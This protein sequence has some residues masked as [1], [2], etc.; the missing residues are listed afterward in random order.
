VKKHI[1][2]ILTTLISLNGYCQ[3]E[4]INFDTDSSQ[5]ELV[6]NSVY[7]IWK[8]SYKNKD[9]VFYSVRYVK[10]TTQI[11]IEGWHRKNGQYIGEWSEYKIDGTWLY[12]IDY[13]KHNW[14]YNKEEF[15]YQ[16]LKDKMKAK[17][18]EILL[19]KFGKEFFEN[20]I[21]FN[22]H[23]NTYIGKWEQFETGKFWM[24][25]KYLGSWIEPI[26]Q[27]PNSYLLDYTIK[28]SNNE[29]YNDKLR[30]ELDSIGNIISNPSRFEINFEEIKNSRKSKFNISREKAIELC[31]K[32]KIE[33]KEITD[34]ES[35]LR[36]GWRKLGEYPGQFY[37]EVVSFINEEKEGECPKQCTIKKY[38]YVWRFDPWTSKLI[39]KEKMVQIT[40]WQDRHGVTGGYEKIKEQ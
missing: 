14:E 10:D 39:H 33:D 2:I 28:L 4:E 37:Y 17:A 23:G 38:Y 35:N 40:T 15:K 24:Q 16:Y 30:I 31:N 11:H 36:L 34:F 29:F 9:S 27:K 13:T 19:N 22:F 21:V 3:F 32:N 26:N 18:D 1:F 7:R 20:N 6:R 25:D 8:E 12:T 5:V